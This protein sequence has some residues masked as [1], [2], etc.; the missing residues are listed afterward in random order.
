VARTDRM[1]GGQE[2]DRGSVDLGPE[3]MVFQPFERRE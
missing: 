3:G 2:D 1:N